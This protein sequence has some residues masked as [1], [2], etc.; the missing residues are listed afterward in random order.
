MEK[1]FKC[2]FKTCGFEA[3]SEFGL[4]AH[5][6]KHKDEVPAVEVPVETPVIPND[7]TTTYAGPESGSVITQEAEPII[8]TPKK[9]TIAKL[10][11]NDGNVIFVFSLEKNGQ[12]WIDLAVKVS[13][14]KKLKLEFE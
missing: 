13:E 1:K 2:Q 14:K 11:D 9:K 7:N 12:E 3:K 6:R 5:M 8:E 4:K 10:I